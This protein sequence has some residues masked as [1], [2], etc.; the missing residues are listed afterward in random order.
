MIPTKLEVL[1]HFKLAEE[2][3]CLVNKINVNISGISDFEFDE[4]ANAFTSIGGAVVFWKDGTYATITKARKCNNC[5]KC[6]CGNNKPKTVKRKHN[7]K[8]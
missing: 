6:N 1:K 2:V 5:K 3:Y 8:S 4:S 7:G